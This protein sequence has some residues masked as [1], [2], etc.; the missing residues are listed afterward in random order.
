[1]CMLMCKCDVH[2]KFEES[3]ICLILQ[4]DISVNYLIQVNHIFNNKAHFK[5]DNYFHT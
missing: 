5:S 3:F 4:S 1:M 2:C